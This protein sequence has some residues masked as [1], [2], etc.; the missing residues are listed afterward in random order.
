[1]PN[2][3]H[4]APVPGRS[5]ARRPGRN[6]RDRVGRLRTTAAATRR[7]RDIREDPAIA[8]PDRAIATIAALTAAAPVTTVP[9]VLPDLAVLAVEGRPDP[10]GRDQVVP[11][12]A[13]V[14]REDVPAARV[15]EVAVREGVQVTAV[16]AALAAA[17]PAFA[18]DVPVAG[19]RNSKPADRT[20]GVGNGSTRADRINVPAT[21]V[22]IVSA[23]E[24]YGSPARNR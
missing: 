11:A 16:I 17:A 23:S 10:V 12:D 8:V 22:A 2:R 1:M 20:T 9:E 14:D 24:R 4:P 15:D 21:I 19:L 7:A 13:P 18:P 3:D 5:R 6:A